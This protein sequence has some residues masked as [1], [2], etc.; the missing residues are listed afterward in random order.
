MNHRTT[1]ASTSTRN[2]V[3][4]PEPPAR[5]S[6]FG[7]YMEEWQGRDPAGFKKAMDEASEWDK[8]DHSKY[9]REPTVDDEHVRYLFIGGATPQFVVTVDALRFRWS[10][11][12]ASPMERRTPPES[13]LKKT[14]KST[15]KV[16]PPFH[17]AGF[18]SRKQRRDPCCHQTTFRRRLEY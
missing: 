14:S 17:T 8:E 12:N 5:P 2:V 11:L 9:L 15:C 7:Q 3:I 16:S 13:G 18:N 6:K 10:A 4:L 1:I